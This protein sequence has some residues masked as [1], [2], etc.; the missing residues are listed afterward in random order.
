LKKRKKRGSPHVPSYDRMQK[1]QAAF[2]GGKH[3]FRKR[4]R[5]H[6]APGNSLSKKGER[7]IS[8]SKRDRTI[9][10]LPIHPPTRKGKKGSS[11][12]HGRERVS[13]KNKERGGKKEKTSDRKAR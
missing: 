6:L 4:Q 7:T 13:Q 1:S 8:S 9:I 10:S 3:F 11:F 12:F 5:T 2:G